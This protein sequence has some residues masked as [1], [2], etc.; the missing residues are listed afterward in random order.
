MKNYDFATHIEYDQESG[1]YIGYIPQLP[2]AL[3]YAKDQDAVHKRLK[4]VVAL[5]LEELP[6]A[7]IENLLPN[8]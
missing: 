6:S 5:C 4:E 8:I 7:E 2:G 1:M 3:T